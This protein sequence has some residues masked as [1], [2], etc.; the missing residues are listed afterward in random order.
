M[1]KRPR[2][3]LAPLDICDIFGNLHRGFMKLGYESHFVNLGV[4]ARKGLPAGTAW[5][6]RYYHSA[7]HRFQAT[8]PLGRLRT[9][10]YIATLDF[11]LAQ[12]LLISWAAWRI[13]AFVLKSGE[14]FLSSRYD[15]LLFRT[16]GKKVVHIFY[17]SDERPPYL[18]PGVGEQGGVDALH[19][20]VILKRQQIDRARRFADITISNPLSAHFQ[21][22]R[23][24]IIQA[25]GIPID[26][27]KLEAR[28]KVESSY[29]LK[30]D[31]IRILHAPSSVDLKGTDRIRAA[32]KT[33]QSRGHAIDYI[34][35]S[36][37][38]NAE[39]MRE[40]ELCDIVVDELYSDSYGAVFATEAIA[41]G[42]PVIVCG[43]G[44]DE[45]DRFV[46]KE[47]VIPALY[48]RPE[49]L[50]FALERLLEDKNLR[51]QQRYRAKQ[52]TAEMVNAQSV[53]KRFLEVIEGRASD[54]W[55]FN[56]TEIRYVEG[57][58]GPE[59]IIA[60]RIR[61]MVDA[62][63]PEALCLDD[64]PELRDRMVAFAERLRDKK[65]A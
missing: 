22:G 16:L 18:N 65:A 50:L 53:A 10:R 45:L 64:K 36:G 28:H 34:Q 57:V 39:V 63:G 27:K 54:S 17:G 60:A 42:R 26:S 61:G 52:F 19:R 49:K 44:Q 47:A 25:L 11:V 40:I 21:T 33:L 5:P 14:S 7:F 13:D 24:C 31:H 51:K 41:I 6:I 23:I 32:I 62:F 30:S 58:A 56:S 15:Q 35:I 1:A 37:R 29:P 4:A 48:Q 55:F 9:L 3:L 2:I 8:R 38:P 12:T 43:Y 20:N 59:E 46:P